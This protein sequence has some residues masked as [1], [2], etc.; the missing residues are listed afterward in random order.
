M[1]IKIFQFFCVLIV[2]MKCC[3]IDPE[4]IE[5][6]KR[7]AEVDCDISLIQASPASQRSQSPVRYGN[8]GSFK[9][10][11]NLSSRSWSVGSFV[12]GTPESES[13]R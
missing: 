1:N 4:L 3:F 5:M 6:V 2:V 10:W 7:S 11:G 8:E 9:D 12:A 13:I